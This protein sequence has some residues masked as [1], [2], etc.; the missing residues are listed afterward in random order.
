MPLKASSHGP[1]KSFL[2]DKHCPRLSN[3]SNQYEQNKSPISKE[4]VSKKIENAKQL[5]ILKLHL[6]PIRC[7]VS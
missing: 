7:Y 2:F 1:I 5:A 3:F 4:W 6:L